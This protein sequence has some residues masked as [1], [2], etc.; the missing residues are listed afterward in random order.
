MEIV[1]II[2]YQR[3]NKVWGFL[4]CNWGLNW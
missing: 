1:P 4:A 2:E 3:Q